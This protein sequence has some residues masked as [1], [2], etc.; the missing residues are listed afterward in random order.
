MEKASIDEVYMDVTSLVEEELRVS[1][2]RLSATAAAEGG[3]A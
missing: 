2:A 1:P 3:M